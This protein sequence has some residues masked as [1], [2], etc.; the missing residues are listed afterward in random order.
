MGEI[1][2]D[3]GGLEFFTIFCFILTCFL[4]H[5]LSYEDGAFKATKENAEYMKKICKEAE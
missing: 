2:R 5:K 4:I 1:F 3:R